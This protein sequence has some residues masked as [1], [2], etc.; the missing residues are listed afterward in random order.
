MNW[1]A[2]MTAAEAQDDS[3]YVE[4]FFECVED[5]SKSSLGWR[6]SRCYEVFLGRENAGFSFRVKARDACHNETAWS[7]AVV[8]DRCYPNG[9]CP[10]DVCN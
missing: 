10:P 1:W 9:S 3:G 6:T 5:S 8:V 4:Y 7:P 2:E